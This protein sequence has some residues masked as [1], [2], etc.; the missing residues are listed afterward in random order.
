MF[1]NTQEYKAICR[2]FLKDKKGIPSNNT[3]LENTIN[4]NYFD[5][6]LIQYGDKIDDLGKVQI[7]DPI[8]VENYLKRTWWHFQQRGF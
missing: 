1:W 4:N 3:Y 2:V 7:E 5:E 6:E 8:E